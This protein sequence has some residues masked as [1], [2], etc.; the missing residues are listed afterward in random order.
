[1]LSAP[2][3]LILTFVSPAGWPSLLAMSAGMGLHDS[4]AM[5]LKTATNAGSP[6]AFMQR[7]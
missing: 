5:R 4:N 3:G 6:Q 2:S 1:M 7:S